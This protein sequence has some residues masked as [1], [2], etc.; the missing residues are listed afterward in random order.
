MTD[1]L[2]HLQHPLVRQAE[3]EWD[4][5]RRGCPQCTAAP[6]PPPPGCPPTQRELYAC[7]EG[8][9]L[10]ELAVRAAQAAYREMV[11]GR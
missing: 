8:M 4:V 11:D 10:H 9:E 3:E 7:N 1:H 6:G 5:H 2:A